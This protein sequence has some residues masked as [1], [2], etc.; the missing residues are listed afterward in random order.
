MATSSDNADRFLKRKAPIHAS[1]KFALKSSVADAK[2]RS[3]RQRVC[4]ACRV[5]GE[6]VFGTVHSEADCMRCHKQP[7]GYG[8]IVGASPTAGGIP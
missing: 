7:M 3:G 8:A 4:E 1:D 5:P 2:R 6:F